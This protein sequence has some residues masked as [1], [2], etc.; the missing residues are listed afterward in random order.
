MLIILNSLAD[1]GFDHNFL[2]CLFLLDIEVV[3]QGIG[4]VE[5]VGA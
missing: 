3:E 5:T 4:Q 1:E 2:L